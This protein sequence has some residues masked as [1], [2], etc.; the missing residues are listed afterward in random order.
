MSKTKKIISILIVLILGL[1]IFSFNV[2][3]TKT[4]DYIGGDISDIP[5]WAI[6]DFDYINLGHGVSITSAYS[7]GLFQLP[8]AS[9]NDLYGGGAVEWTQENIFD[10][11]TKKYVGSDGKT[12]SDGNLPAGY[13]FTTWKFDFNKAFSGTLRFSI[14]LYN[15]QILASSNSRYFKVQA[16]NGGTV[17]GATFSFNDD[18]ANIEITG[19]IPRYI[20]VQIPFKLRAD[21]AVCS[22]AFN[23][24]YHY[25][26]SGQSEKQEAENVGGQGSQEMENS[27][28]QEHSEGAVS[29][30]S[31]FASAMSDENAF[32][33]KLEI[34]TIKIPAIPNVCD[35]IV[36]AD[37]L[38]V[39]FDRY[40]YDEKFIPE[41]IL[42]LVQYIFSI[43]LV[44]YCVKELYGWIEYIL[45]LRKGN[46]D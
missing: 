22:C 9:I 14:S 36:L 30:L 46:G 31:H 37:N 10:Y 8:Y 4:E 18:I 13:Y 41:N 39:D 45:T 43:A 3:A 25:D 6:P 29:A 16:P 2:S 40:L 38:V 15:S 12:Y 33:L 1:S 34:P 20:V 32:G 11:Y 42:T 26:E 23:F 35:E 21:T 44:L 7:Q 27:I 28:S 19:D 17:A 5:Y 24:Y